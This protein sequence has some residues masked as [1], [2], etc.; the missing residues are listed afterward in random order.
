MSEPTATRRYRILLTTW[1]H[2]GAGSIQSVQ[3]LAE[4]LLQRGHQVLV[5]CP[6]DGVLGRRLREKGVP[7]ADFHFHKGWHLGS[8]RRLARLA[9]END[10]EVVDAQESRDR[11]AAILARRFFG[12]KAALVVTRRQQTA[13]FP[14]GNLIYALAAD[15]VVAISQGV[16][17]TL[18]RRGTPRGKIRV[19]HT[20]LQSERISGEVG[21]E[22]LE[23]TRAELGLDPRL[24]T[25]GVVARRKDQETL[26]R[27][28]ALLGRPVNVVMAGIERDPALARLEAELPQGAGVAY[29]GFREDVLSLYRLMDIK[30]LPTTS[31]GLSQALLEAMALGVPVVTAAVGGT[32]ELVKQG[33][34]GLLFP[35]GDAAEL[36]RCLAAL[37]DDGELRARLAEAARRTVQGGFTAQHLAARTEAV[38]DEVLARG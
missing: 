33:E 13:T 12:M 22:R 19:V 2:F 4:G 36:A 14:L 32:P 30:V 6:A 25:I 5:A 15:R 23:A 26:L 35:P 10:I 31:E 37:L 8:A 18:V 38:Y 9:R 16:A 11:K 20:G 3:Y 28:V 7:L 34:N 29:T 1:Q 24:P 27:A 17:E 21:A